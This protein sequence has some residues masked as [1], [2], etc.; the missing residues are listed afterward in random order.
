MI[1]P[2][3]RNTTFTFFC[4]IVL[5]ACGEN[6]KNELQTNGIKEHDEVPDG[7]RNL[8]VDLADRGIKIQPTMYGIFFEDINFG[9]DGGLYSELIKNRSFEF[10]YAK[11]GWEQP[12]SVR[13]SLNGDSGFAKITDYTSSKGNKKYAHI[14][15]NNDQNYEL[16]NEGFRGIGLRKG[17][18]YDLSVS[19]ANAQG[20]DKVYFTLIDSLGTALAQTQIDANTGHWKKNE[21]VI[22]PAKTE[23]HAKLKVTFEGNGSIDMDL[24]SLFPKNTWKG[25][26]G[27]LRKDLIELLD[28]LNPGFVRFPG[29]CI[30][31]GRT[32]AERYQ[33]K[34]TVGPVDDRELLVNRWNMEFSHRSAPDY[35]HF[36]FQRIWVQNHCLFW[37]VVWHVS[38]T[39]GNWL[40]WMNWIP[41]LMMQ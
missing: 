26:K 30:V 1:K 29:G 23:T 14:V 31:E 25:R 2:I 15:V 6:Q 12:N 9:A 13:Y 24:V 28:G 34:K 35:Y 36:S 38:S 20:I 8:T 5:M 41:T 27:G 3:F 22:T 21:V 10:P 37:G 39:L 18:E 19:L 32:L 7:T 4:L 33:W 17:E 40:Q 11:M 16:I